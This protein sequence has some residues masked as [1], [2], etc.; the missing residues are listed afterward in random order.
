MITIT[1]LHPTKSVELQSWTFEA[2]PV[3][4]IGR[5]TDN[6]VIVH[7]SVVSRHHLE[8]WN[9]PDNWEIINFGSNGTY[10]NDKPITQSALADGMVVRLG[11]AGPKLR[12]RLGQ[13]D[14]KAIA[15]TPRRSD[16]SAFKEGKPM[17]EESMTKADFLDL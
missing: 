7:S 14:S 5:A 11:I 15:K 3:V 6:D 10:I 16:K 12:I 13:G 17:G 9:N 8:L 4:R 2:E 1:L